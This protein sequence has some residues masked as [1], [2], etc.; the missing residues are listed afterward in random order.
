MAELIQNAIGKFNAGISPDKW[1]NWGGA[2]IVISDGTLKITTTTAASYWGLDFKDRFN[3]TGSSVIVY[4]SDAGAQLADRSMIPLLVT[5]DSNNTMAIYIS[6]GTLG[7]QKQVATSYSD[8]GSTAFN[9]S[10]MKYFRLRESSG[11]IYGEYSADRSSWTTIGSTAT[12]FD[13]TNL[14]LTIEA[15]NNAIVGSG[16]TMIVDNLN[17]ITNDIPGNIG[18]SVRVAGGINV[19]GSNHS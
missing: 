15:G 18:R 6:N 7:F 5:L 17:V 13:I 14:I 4:V 8:V 2:Q 1:T 19:S 16:A 9:S 12:P 11:T 10:T 3:L